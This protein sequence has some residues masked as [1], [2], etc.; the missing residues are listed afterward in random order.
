MQHMSQNLSVGARPRY[1]GEIVSQEIGESHGWHTHEFGQL[2]SASYG[3]MYVGTRNRVLLLSPAMAIW[4]PP[5]AEHWIR[6]A[7]NNEML[8]VDVN[9]EEAK[10]FGTNSRIVAMTPLLSALM[11]ATMP[12]VSSD[13]TRHHTDALHDLLRHEL[14][15]ARDIPLSIAMPQDRR[16]HGMAQAALE[17]PGSI[18]SVDA[19]LMN[20]AASRKT[21]E[22][23]FLA[24]TGMP[25][26]RWLRHARI[27]HAIS[28]LAAGRKI[29]SVAF[30]LGYESASAFTFM[31]R[32]T[33][34]MC[35]SS[36][37]RKAEIRHRSTDNCR[38]A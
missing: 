1:L 31:F 27:L 8:Y 5:D 25:P 4:I 21:I 16:I 24:E 6:Y 30:D 9:R 13:H 3:S 36:F 22:R 29:S 38:R 19:W 15:A 11:L 14:I 12:D 20:A 32:S 17:N 23:L 37:F 33:L 10:K 2:I 18:A 34:G 26:S 28:Q 7:S 35:P